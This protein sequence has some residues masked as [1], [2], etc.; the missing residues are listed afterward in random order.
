MIRRVIRVDRERYLSDAAFR[1]LTMQKARREVVRLCGREGAE[2]TLKL[3]AGRWIETTATFTCFPA[4][5]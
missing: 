2:I 3:V 4:R 1:D 5:P